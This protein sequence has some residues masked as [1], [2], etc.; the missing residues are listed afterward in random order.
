MR[1]LVTFTHQ[2]TAPPVIQAVASR[3]GLVALIVAWDEGLIHPGCRLQVEMDPP[4]TE[5]RKVLL[6]EV[7]GCARIGRVLEHGEEP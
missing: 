1:A 2:G 6:G 3:D 7:M 4:P 5:F